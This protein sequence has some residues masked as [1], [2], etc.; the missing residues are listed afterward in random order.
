MK[1]G[2]RPTKKQKLVIQA[3]GLKPEEYLVVKSLHDQLHVVDRK[4]NQKVIQL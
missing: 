4:G 2:K 1:N 3:E